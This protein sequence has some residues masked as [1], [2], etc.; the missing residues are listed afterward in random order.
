MSMLKNKISECID[1]DQIR[2]NEIS[3]NDIWFEVNTLI[4]I[5]EAV[6]QM[7]ESYYPF[8]HD[9]NRKKILYNKGVPCKGFWIENT[10]DLVLYFTIEKYF[11]TLVVGKDD[12]MV[13]DDIT[14]N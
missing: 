11:D 7:L 12:W 4:C 8:D 10:K 9:R 6:M 13:R 14:I 2:L 1:I 5:R 3:L